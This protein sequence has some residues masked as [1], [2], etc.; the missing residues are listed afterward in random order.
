MSLAFLTVEN[1]ASRLHWRN[2]KVKKIK[3]EFFI[4]QEE[5]RRKETK[6]FHFIHFLTT[7][8]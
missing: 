6:E 8:V 5:I 4:Q 3:L 2:E 7:L 1:S